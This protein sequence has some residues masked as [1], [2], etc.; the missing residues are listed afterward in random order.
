MA[1]AAIVPRMLKQLTENMHDIGGRVLHSFSACVDGRMVTV[2]SGGRVYLTALHE[3]NVVPGL[4]NRFLARLVDRVY[5]GWAAAQ[6]SFRKASTLV[7]GNPIRPEVAAVGAARARVPGVDG[8]ARILVTG[9]SQGSPFLNEHAPELLRRVAALGVPIDIR[10]QTGQHD[11]EPVRRAYDRAGLAAE[12]D[13]HIDDMPVAY[14]AA[15]FA[16]V[17]PG[18]ITLAELAAAGLPCLLVPLGKAAGDHQTPNAVAFA[19]ATGC[20]CV[21]GTSTR[22]LTWV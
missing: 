10:H 12:V 17:C 16:V 18:A 7:S 15:D 8:R 14:R 11:P 19:E 3:A 13:R 20:A 22:G 5:L 2:L 1:L 4:T 6:D 21:L 9:G